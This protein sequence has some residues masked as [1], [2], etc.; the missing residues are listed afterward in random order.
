MVPQA[1]VTNNGNG[2]FS[3][4]SLAQGASI[5]FVV[6]YQIGATFQGTSLTTK[7]RSPRI[8]ATTLTPRRTTTYRQKTIR[9]T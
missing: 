3:I 4:A 6:N 8:T 9:T 5:S 7:R 1:G 2:T